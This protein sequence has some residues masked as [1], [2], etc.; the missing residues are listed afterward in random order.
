MEPRDEAWSSVDR[1]LVSQKFA[2]LSTESQTGPYSSLVAF[3]AAPDLQRVVF[4]TMRATRKFTFLVS[5]PRVSLLF[6]DRSNSDD[7]VEEATAVTA[8]GV[9][10]ELTDT[11]AR[12]AVEEAFLVKH[13]RL[14]SF[15]ASPECALVRVDLDVFY[16][17]TRFREMVELQA[18]DARS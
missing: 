17:V 3:W 6:D 1:L 5:H 9:A 16:V 4:P 8:T 7:D 13:P 10:R 15:V 2:V 12:A 18:R 14:A 11:V